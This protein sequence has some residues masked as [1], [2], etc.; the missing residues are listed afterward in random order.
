MDGICWHYFF[1]WSHIFFNSLSYINTYKHTHTH[2]IDAWAKSNDKDAPHTAE[3]LLRKLLEHDTLT[4]DAYSYHG[5]LEAWSQSQDPDALRRL[6]QIYK[7]MVSANLVKNIRTFNS[8]LSAYAKHISKLQDKNDMIALATEAHELLQQEKERFAQTQDSDQQ[9]DAF[10]YSIMIDIFGRCGVVKSTLQAESLLTE[11]K[12]LYSQQKLE[13]LL[14]NVRTYTSL[15]SAWSKTKSDK[16]A[17]RGEELLQEMLDGSSTEMKPN[18]R[19]YA[20]LCTCWARSQDPTKATRV[21]TLVR[22]MKQQFETNGDE[23]CKPSLLVYNSAIDACSRCCG[24]DKQQTVAL[25]IAFAMNK[26]LLLDGLVPDAMTFDRLMQATAY[27]MPN[28]NERNGVACALLDKAKNAGCVSF[29]VVKNF[30]KA[31]DNN[32]VHEQL[33]EMEDKHGQIDYNNVPRTWAK[34]L[35]K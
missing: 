7:H 28:G 6:Q 24:D 1:P 10:T 21:L 17:V 32:V 26:A 18:Q 2:P 33:K 16:A 4:P 27:L 35:M 12:E 13:K 23:N 30:R 34:N 29:D 20:A 25:K 11:L 19:T 22:N 31:V 14:P 3:R 9:P 8:L 15:I 5:I